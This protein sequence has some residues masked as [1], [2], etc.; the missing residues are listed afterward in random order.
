[1][2]TTTR[3]PALA[4]LAMLAA[5]MM[6]P[7][8]ATQLQAAKGPKKIGAVTHTTA[9]AF[10]KNKVESTDGPLTGD[11]DYKWYLQ[12]AAG[13]ITAGGGGS[14]LDKFKG[15][16]VVLGYRL[17]REDRIQIEI[18]YNPGTYSGA[19][20]WSMPVQLPGIPSGASPGVVS[21]NVTMRGTAGAK[22]ALMPVLISWSYCVRPLSSPKFGFLSTDRLEMRLTPVFGALAMKGTWS[23]RDATGIFVAK[24]GDVIQFPGSNGSTANLAMNPASGSNTT[25]LVATVGIGGGVTYNFGNR[26]QV[27]IDYRYLLVPKVVNNPPT[28]QTWAPNPAGGPAWDGQ[29]WNSISAWNGMNVTSITASLGWKF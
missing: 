17:S 22:A 16:N 2:K 14:V 28:G 1:M 12:L 24:P 7:S 9:S 27:D 13:Y 23:M 19:F 4:I 26:W 18:G 3:K 15:A 8:L 25:R 10:K 21:N 11:V 6:L 20:S 29:P 5:G